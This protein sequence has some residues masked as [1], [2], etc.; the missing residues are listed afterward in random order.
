MG[1][2]L[3]IHEPFGKVY[4]ERNQEAEPKPY[5]GGY[6]YPCYVVVSSCHSGMRHLLLH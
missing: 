3:T 5:I 6:F 1:S 2:G 4:F